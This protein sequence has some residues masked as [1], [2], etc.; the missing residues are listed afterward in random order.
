MCCIVRLNN[1]EKSWDCPCHGSRF[2]TNGQ[3]LEGPAMRALSSIEQLT[4]KNLTNLKDAEAPFSEDEKVD[5]ASS[6]SYSQAIPQVFYRNPLRM[7]SGIG[8]T[9]RLP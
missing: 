7:E 9:F 3:V 6:E 1:A 4:A 5:E 2:E 8:L